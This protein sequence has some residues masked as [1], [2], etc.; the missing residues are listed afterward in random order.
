MPPI[1][2]V[3]AYYIQCRAIHY[4][5]ILKGGDNKNYHLGNFWGK[6]FMNGPFFDKSSIKRIFFVNIMILKN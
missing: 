6:A 3:S 5:S 1:S 4:D 2:N